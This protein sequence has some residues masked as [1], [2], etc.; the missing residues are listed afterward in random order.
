MRAFLSPRFY[1]IVGGSFLSLRFYKIIAESFSLTSILQNNRW[2]LFSHFE[3]IKSWVRAHLSL[4]FWQMIHWSRAHISLHGPWWEKS[5][6]KALIDYFVKSR[7]GS[8]EK[9]SHQLFGKFDVRRFVSDLIPTGITNEPRLWV[10]ARP[11][12]KRC[13]QQFFNK[14]SARNDTAPYKYSKISNIKVFAPSIYS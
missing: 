5:E 13:S 9:I 3:F 12:W 2:E 1:Q 6:R 10:P 11:G 8:W 4:Q 7:W 14:A